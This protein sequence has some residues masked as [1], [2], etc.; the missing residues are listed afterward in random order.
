MRL[1]TVGGL[2]LFL[3]I[4]MG[5]GTAIGILTAP[6]EWY[7]ALDKPPFNPP[8]W[9]FAPVWTVLYLFIA[10]AGWRTW[11]GRRESPAMKMWC[12]QLALNFLWSPVFFVAHR[13]DIALGIILLLLATIIGFAV[14]TWRHD[15]VASILFWPYAAW[16]G[17]A[18][19]LN[20]ALVV[21]N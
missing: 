15:R 19:A 17:F 16:V 13:M 21:L 9:V 3:V 10:I 4:V 18:S 5:G 20:G 6:G 14:V 2:A 1:K 11:P 12:A 7:A 8:N